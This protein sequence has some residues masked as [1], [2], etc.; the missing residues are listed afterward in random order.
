[1]FLPATFQCQATNAFHCKQLTTKDLGCCSLFLQQLWAK[2]SCIKE[3]APRQ[4][5][6]IPDPPSILDL[7]GAGGRSAWSFKPDKGLLAVI[8]AS[9][10]RATSRSSTSVGLFWN[11]RS[12]RVREV[13]VS[14]TAASDRVFLGPNSIGVD[15]LDRHE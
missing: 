15:A 7:K 9:R 4:S 3:A 12:L 14:N 6:P 13:V 1:V 5:R 2:R 10:C 11:D 8:R